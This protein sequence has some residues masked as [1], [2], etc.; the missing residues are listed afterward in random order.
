[1]PS[2]G[3][4]GLPGTWNEPDGEVLRRLTRDAMFAASGEAMKPGPP[5]RI[6][7]PDGRQQG[8][9]PHEHTKRVVRAALR[10]LLANGLITVTPPEERPEWVVLDPPGERA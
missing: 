10:M 8:E 5:S 4:T 9:T 3:T 6:R 7:D 1:M 2:D